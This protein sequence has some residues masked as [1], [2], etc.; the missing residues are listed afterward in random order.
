MR[1]VLKLSIAS[2]LV[3][4]AACGKKEAGLAAQ[5]ETPA[6]AA[7][8]AATAAATGA[9]PQFAAQEGWVAESPTSSMRF[10]QFRIP[11]AAGDAE[12][13]VFHFGVGGGGSVEDNF[14]R[15]TGQFEAEGP[16]A[17]VVPVRIDWEADG[18]K[19][20]N[21]ELAGKYAAGMGP[22]MGGGSAVSGQRMIA[23]ILECEGGPFFVKFVGPD[24]TVQR[25]RESYSEFLKAFRP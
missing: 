21:L 19:F 24:S 8:G 22:A 2:S 9:G 7:T 20:H 1:S 10:A 3:L 16:D 18:V 4:L 23:T 11:D 12:V 17:P 15:W 6:G 25:H 5:P 13:V 14:Q